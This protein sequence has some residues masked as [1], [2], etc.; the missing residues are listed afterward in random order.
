MAES[1]FSSFLPSQV[2]RNRHQS[3]PRQRFVKCTSCPHLTA[4]IH[5]KAD[6][7]TGETSLP[8]VIGD[9]IP[10][11]RPAANTRLG[12]EGTRHWALESVTKV[13][14]LTEIRER[15]SLREQ[16]TEPIL[17]T[18]PRPV[19]PSKIVSVPEGELLENKR[20]GSL[21]AEEARGLASLA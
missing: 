14:E 20:R 2:N 18:H 12:Y 19:A 3:C 8:T 9:L 21:S 16:Q 15:M 10:T 4:L 17:L 1:S 6:I 13:L 5:V 7:A 11:S